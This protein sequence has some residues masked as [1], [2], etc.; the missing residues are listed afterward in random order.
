MV[1]YLSNPKKIKNN[2]KLKKIHIK[3]AI[4]TKTKKTQI[5]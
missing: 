2:K 3:K 1:K 5:S 4:Q